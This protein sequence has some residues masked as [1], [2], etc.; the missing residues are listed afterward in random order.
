MKEADRSISAL[1]V[2]DDEGDG[3]DSDYGSI[4]HDDT[5]TP[6]ISSTTGD[7]GDTIEIGRSP[8]R[9]VSKTSR[10]PS[11]PG[12][13][14]PK[15]LRTKLEQWHY[16]HG[17]WPNCILGRGLRNVNMTSSGQEA[18]W[19]HVSGQTLAVEFFRL[20]AQRRLLTASGP[21]L[22]PF[23]IRNDREGHTKGG[24]LSLGGAP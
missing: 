8:R 1:F 13:E 14:I 10:A 5:F 23:I 7:D 22:G 2:S 12:S 6:E 16:R 20:P 21:G 3:E 4:A 11:R 24:E 18:K 9:K 15:A 17:S 19:T